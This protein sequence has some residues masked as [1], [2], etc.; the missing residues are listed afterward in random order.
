MGEL[1][2]YYGACDVAFVGG[3]LLP[4]GGQNIIEACAMG[5]PVLVGPHTFNFAEVTGLAETAG[6]ARRVSDAAELAAEARRLLTDADTRDH[7]RASAL[8]FAEAHRGATGRTLHLIES[9]WS[10]SP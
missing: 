5:T 1:F 3:S 8:A 4:L 6:A 9:R 7:M 10:R 2:A